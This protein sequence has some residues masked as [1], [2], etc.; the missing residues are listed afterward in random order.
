MAAQLPRPL[1]PAPRVYTKYSKHPIGNS[2]RMRMICPAGSSISVG[3]PNVNTHSTATSRVNDQ[4]ES[5]F[6]RK[7]IKKGKPRYASHSILTDQAG[8]FQLYT[9]GTRQA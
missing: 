4:P 8:L 6:A 9:Y 3:A 1:C 5:N 7:R 2:D